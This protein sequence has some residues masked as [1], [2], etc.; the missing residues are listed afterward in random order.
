LISYGSINHI[1]RHGELIGCIT[2]YRVG[3]CIVGC[4]CRFV[5]IHAVVCCIIRAM[6]HTLPCHPFTYD[7]MYPSHCLCYS[8]AHAESY[9][10]VT[11]D[12]HHMMMHIVS[13]TIYCHCV[14]RIHAVIIRIAWLCTCPP[15]CHYMATAISLDNNLSLTVVCRAS[16]HCIA[17]ICVVCCVL[18]ICN[19]KP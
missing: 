10:D 19:S 4:V 2:V 11:V 9:T 16:A 15:A 1:T 14:M 5:C 3:H 8:T 12:V 7:I 6:L 13:L 17:V 18:L